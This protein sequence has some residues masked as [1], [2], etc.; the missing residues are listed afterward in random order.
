[1]SIFD[2][3]ADLLATLIASTALFQALTE[4]VEVAAAKLK[5]G[6]HESADE[7][8]GEIT[9]PR[10]TIY[11]GGPVE[12][13]KIGTGVWRGSGSLFLLFE[14]EVPLAN[15]TSLQAQREYFV[16]K[17]ATIMRQAEV[18]ADSRATPTGYS[19]SHLQMKRYTKSSG[20]DYVL[21]SKREK[22][23]PAGTPDL[24]LWQMEF[25]VEY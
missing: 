19:T 7:G 10:A 12:R 1:M 11:E 15:A 17:V 3:Q 13:Q 6:L 14:I 20:P 8:A 18:I 5:I 24:T 4:T 22:K 2:G 9:F 25:E 23:S 21:A 16:T